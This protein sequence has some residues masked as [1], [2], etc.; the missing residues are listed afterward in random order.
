LKEYPQ[1]PPAAAERMIVKDNQKMFILIAPQLIG[2][3][4]RLLMIYPI[5]MGREK[6][7]TMDPNRLMVPMM[8][9]I[10]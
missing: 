4:A 7:T 2:S 9:R 6:S 8:I 3:D 1:T 5:K 10:F